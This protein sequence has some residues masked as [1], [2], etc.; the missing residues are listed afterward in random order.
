MCDDMI[1]KRIRDLTL[2]EP[3]R[4]RQWEWARLHGANPAEAVYLAAFSA[5]PRD[6]GAA[7]RLAQLR[8][9]WRTP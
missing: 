9:D 5:D 7:A 8:A 6:P 3:T 2:D 4:T 1:T